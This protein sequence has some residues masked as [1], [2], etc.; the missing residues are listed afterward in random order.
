MRGPMYNL[1]SRALNLTPNGY[2]IKIRLNII[3]PTMSSSSKQ[4]LSFNTQNTSL[5]L[6]ICYMPHPSHPPGFRNPH[7]ICEQYKSRSFSLHNFIQSLISSSLLGPTIFLNTLLSNTFNLCS[8][9]HVR[10]Q[11]PHP[12]TTTHKIIVLC[13]LISH[14]QI[15]NKDRR[16][17]TER[18]QVLS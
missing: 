16:F 10:N 6:H 2:N 11:V 13:I 14:Y 18:Q 1:T 5:L 4:S 3:P 8:S 12:F 7:Q 9:R 15:R 17:W